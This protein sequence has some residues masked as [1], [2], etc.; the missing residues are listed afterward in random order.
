M[1]SSET[2]DDRQL[3]W[4]GCLNVR[5]LGGLPT[6]DGRRT[7]RGAVVRA[8]NLDSLTDEGWAALRAYGVRTVVDLRDEADFRPR[9]AHPADVELVRVP[10]DELAGPDWWARFGALDGTPLSFRPY[11]DDCPH[12]VAA[13]V[14]AVATARPGG[15]VVH[16]GAGRDRTGL[17]TLVLLAVAGVRAE[18]IAAD[19]LLS[20]ENLRPLWGMLGRPDEAAVTEEI[21]REA[22]TTAEAAL[23]EVLAE[24]EPESYL[25]AAELAAV[26]ARL[27]G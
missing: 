23:R 9:L 19:Y 6:V 22:G 1:R 24:F 25:P 16:C 13:L 8:D 2:T 5:D 18:A 17:A 20:T 11:L 7:R 10:L 14:R 3:A 26:R 27:L 4:D 21:L 12:A 15:V